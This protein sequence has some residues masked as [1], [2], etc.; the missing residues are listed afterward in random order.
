MLY[1]YILIFVLIFLIIAGYLYFTSKLEEQKDFYEKKLFDLPR[2]FLEKTPSKV[3]QKEKDKKTS[4]VS[5]KN[6]LKNEEISLKDGENSLEKKKVVDDENKIIT[7]ADF[8]IFKGSKLLL[9]E[10]NFINQKIFISI[11]NKSGIDITIANNGKEA[12]DL[13]FNNEKVFDLVLMDIN[14]PIMDGYEATKR[15]RD[16]HYFEKL[17]IVAFTAFTQGKEINKMIK[18]GVNAYIT[19]P[20]KVDKLYS[21]L[22]TYLGT[23]TKE[24]SLFESIKT[25]GLDIKFG[26]TMANEDEN[27]YKQSLREFVVLYKNMIETM[28]KWI[29]AK[30]SDRIL[31]VC[32][33]MGDILKYIGAYELQDIVFRMKKI[34]IYKTAHRADEFKEIFPQKLERLIHAIERYLSSR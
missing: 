26:L 15:I 14:M 10:D 30:E 23:Y 13:I 27:G 12:I 11:L 4:S 5:E 17:P 33:N 18:L 34:Y 21:V 7:S 20:L 28:P 6:S 3:I 25:E 1:L 8:I 22:S 29:E 9:V 31:F 24:I 19:K 16:N 32:T 2:K